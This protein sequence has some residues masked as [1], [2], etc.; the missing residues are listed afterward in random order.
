MAF[1]K[2]IEA[3]S[4]VNSGRHMLWTCTPD[5]FCES[6]IYIQSILMIV[7]RVALYDL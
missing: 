1:L 4:T 3:L 2:P 6:L 5:T 7:F